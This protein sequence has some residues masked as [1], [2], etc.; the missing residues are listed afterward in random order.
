[1]A[2]AVSCDHSIRL[3]EPITFWSLHITQ[4]FPCAFVSTRP[5][6]PNVNASQDSALLELFNPYLPKTSRTH[7][8][9][10]SAMKIAKW[11][12]ELLVGESQVQ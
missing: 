9:L 4:T 11:R 7:A 2:T 3:F 10:A 1:M 6:P 5:A 8:G 12:K